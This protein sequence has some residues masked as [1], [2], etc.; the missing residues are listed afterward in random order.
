MWDRNF[1][2]CNNDGYEKSAKIKHLAYAKVV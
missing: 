1:I 2:S